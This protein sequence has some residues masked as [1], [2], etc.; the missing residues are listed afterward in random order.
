[1]YVEGNILGNS[2]KANGKKNS[3]IGTRTKNAKTLQNFIDS[4]VEYL[5]YQKQI[6]HGISS[7]F[8]FPLIIKKGLKVNL[9]KFRS[10]LTSRK[11][12]TRPIICGNIAKQP[13][14]KLYKHRVSGSL[15]NSSYIMDNGL[16][17]PNHQNI[18]KPSINTM[19][20]AIIE[21]FN[22]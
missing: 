20:Q 2:L 14:M 6:P 12:E 21:F 7:H 15:K 4:N 16:A 9:A 1:M 13:G 11:I 10:Y 5:T 17:I 8:G 19:K 3:I 22:K 18:G